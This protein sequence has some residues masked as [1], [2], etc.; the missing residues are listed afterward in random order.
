MKNILG[1]VFVLAILAASP[2]VA[3]H[4]KHRGGDVRHSTGQHMGGGHQS[5]AVGQRTFHR[6]SA[7]RNFTVHERVRPRHVTVTTRRHVTST[8][9]IHHATT[10]HR[11]A[12]FAHLRR[13][14]RAPHRFHVGI[15]RRPAG[16]YAHRWVLGQRLPRAWFGRDYWIVDFGIY[17]LI[18]PPDGLIWVRVGDDAVLIDQYT[19]EVIQIEYGI[20]Y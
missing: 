15:Y 3:Q 5:R 19:G 11:S 7:H 4:D 17:G 14:F 9:G 16:W 2:G 13:S 10:V 20:F 8:R 18:P 12:R 1:S 6:Q